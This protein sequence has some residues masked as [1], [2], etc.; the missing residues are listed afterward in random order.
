MP[1]KIA[2]YTAALAA[3]L[4]ACGGGGGGGGGGST[5]SNPNGTGV[6]PSSAANVQP[7]TASA[8]ITG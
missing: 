5:T 2:W 1:L 7:V 6:T 3:T 4:A 8:G